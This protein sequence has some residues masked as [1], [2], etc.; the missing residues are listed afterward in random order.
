MI[1][2]KLLLICCISPH[3]SRTF[4]V[5]LERLLVEFWCVCADHCRCRFSF[6]LPVSY[7]LFSFLRFHVSLSS[8]FVLLSAS[9][10]FHLLSN[11]SHTP[12]G[13]K[14]VNAVQ[15]LW[16]IFVTIIFLAYLA[17]YVCK[18]KVWK[19]YKT[20]DNIQLLLNRKITSTSQFNKDYW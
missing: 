13:K 8:S 16:K 5:F 14:Y 1:W 15:Y 19:V 18:N 12:K 20:S 9:S 3:F 11:D 10:L 6:F 17:K 2:S 7:Y 4:R